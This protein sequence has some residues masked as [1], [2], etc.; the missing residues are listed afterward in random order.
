M[1]KRM[2][3]VRKKRH[4]ER[5]VTILIIAVSMIFVLGMAG[6]GIDLAS[7]YVGRSEAQRAADAAALAGANALTDPSLDCVSA[8]GGS[9]SGNCQAIAI[10]NAEAVG[11]MNLIA[12]VSPDIGKISTDIKFLSTSAS[13]PQIQVIASRNTAHNNPMPTFFI[14]IFGIDSANVS[15]KAVA[16]AYI[17]TGGGLSETATCVKPWLVPNC[18]SGNTSPAA[19]DASAYC[20]DPTT[21]NPVG[22]YVIPST[23]GSTSTSVPTARDTY[24]PTGY[25]GEPITL[26]PGTPGDAAAPGQY[27]A[28][29]LPNDSYVP[30]DCP[31]CVGATPSKGGTG[32]AA[33]YREN[34]ECCNTNPDVC[35]S[36]DVTLASAAGNMVGPTEQGVECLTNQSSNCGQDHLVGVSSPCSAKDNP[37]QPVT[38]KSGF[39]IIAG[40]NNLNYT[41]GDS[42]PNGNSSSL[43]L[44]PIWNGVP[45]QSGQNSNISIVGFMQVFVQDVDK[46][47][48]GTV[49]GTIVRI[50][51]CGS[52]S[53][54]AGSPGAGAVAADGGSAIAVRL[55]HE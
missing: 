17:P 3:Q 19:G 9:I 43:V 16:E 27:Y 44:L 40:P 11:N 42:I 2:G 33:I 45:L 48:Q 26:K 39:E 5:G 47:N 6:L 52:G 53:N 14:K 54:V 46:S 32:S 21:G 50:I 25:K 55:I 10:Q 12:G 23:D 15:A 7:L 8:S 4:G 20:T 30:T 22:M 1:M 29:Y 34:I 36:V 18:D 37:P 13:D 38:S 31:S 51:P 49:Y 28:A 24:Y 35:G 41:P